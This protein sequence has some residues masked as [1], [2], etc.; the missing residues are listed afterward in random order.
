MPFLAAALMVLFLLNP[1]SS[2]RADGTIVCL[3][4]G[5]GG[6][7]PG[8]VGNGVLEKD[9][10]LDIALRAR[11]LLTGMGYQVVMTRV[12]DVYVSLEDR[13][14][15]ANTSGAEAFLSIH[16]NASSQGGE[17]TETY[18]YYDSEEGRILAKAVHYQVVSRIGLKNRGV[19][20]A[21]FYVLK[22][23]DMP[24]ALLEGA[25]ITNSKEADLLKDPLFRQKIAEGISA[26]LAEFLRDPGLFSEYISI[27]NP[28]SSKRAKVAVDFIAADGRVRKEIFEILQLGRHSIF[29]DREIRSAD[30]S[31]VVRS[32]NGVAVVCERSMYFDFSGFN[33]G[34]CSSGARGLSK[35]WYLAEGSTAWGFSTF[36][37]VF[38]PQKEQSKITVRLLRSDGHTGS[39]EFV[40]PSLSRLTID[41]STL[42]G[43]ENADFSTVVLAEKPVVAERA[44]YF[45]DF[46][47]IS[48]GHAS[49]AVA[50]PYCR[51]Y[52]AEGYTGKGFD[53]FILI[54]NP[55][56]IRAKVHM[57]SMLPEGKTISN[58]FGV[59]PMS[60]KT[61]HLNSVPG[62]QSTDVSTLLYSDIA[63]IA[64]RSVYFNYNGI[65]DGSNCFGS[66][67]PLKAS[68]LAEG[69]TGEGFDTFVLLMNP[70]KESAP[71][72]V[73][74]LLPGVGVK[75][76]GLILPAFSRKTIQ[77]NN[78]TG[79]KGKEFSVEILSKKRI[80]AE[81]AM[82]FN[83]GNQ[84]GGHCVTASRPSGVWYFAEGCTR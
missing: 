62:L 55:N 14:K 5:H 54:S 60:R 39:F 27:L 2:L 32:E 40:L 4:P 63:V 71:V 23:T 80:A 59:E 22:N 34:H 28:D 52:F 73:R 31:S 11:N 37:L 49:C 36:I 67:A 74:F 10:N 77:V 84:Q 82:Y 12:K 69:Y 18:C 57:L 58:Y 9:V 50:K 41:T 78:V 3:D 16:N 51:W 17:G 13:C 21:G 56:K 81:R 24:S 6:S 75:S 29:V 35:V 61:I 8:A 20:E 1:L 15:I 83:K 30:V 68:Y 19:K 48:G 79:L 70:N 65:K 46:K 66:P 33:G 26:G 42:R 38:N 64:E 7:D 43:F 25:F 76:I 72:T 44:V 47:G 53:T 45:S